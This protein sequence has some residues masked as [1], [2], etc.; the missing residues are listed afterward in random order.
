[1]KRH[2]T[3]KEFLKEFYPSLTQRQ[4][5]K[6]MNGSESIISKMK[7]KQNY[8]LNCGSA[9]VITNWIL[10]HH[11]V[12]II[13]DSPQFKMEKDFQKKFD[14]IIKQKDEKIAELEAIIKDLQMK[15]EFDDFSR[16]YRKYYENQ[17]KKENKN[18][19][20]K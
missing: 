20:R 2:M 18:K 8:D 16:K 6:L 5:A 9:K 15:I 12:V 10:Q 14:A 17:I 1:M 11:N 19:R 4:F 7:T 3:M 13:Y